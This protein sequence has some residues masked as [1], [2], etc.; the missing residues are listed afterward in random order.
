MLNGMQRLR[1]RQHD[2]HGLFE[3]AVPASIANTPNV[4]MVDGEV[5]PPFAV[6]SGSKPKAWR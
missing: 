2:L 3:P 6:L 5:S 1:Q 4:S